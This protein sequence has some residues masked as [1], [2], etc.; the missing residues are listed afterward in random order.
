VWLEALRWIVVNDDP[1]EFEIRP[2]ADRLSGLIFA[3]VDERKQ[4]KNRLHLDLH[5]DDQDAEVERV[6]ALGAPRV[7]VGQGDV[8]W[9]VLADQ[10]G[11]EFCVLRDR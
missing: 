5:P 6:I 11:N 9:E 4:F 8:P 2:P 10:K 7:D 1:G 3:Q